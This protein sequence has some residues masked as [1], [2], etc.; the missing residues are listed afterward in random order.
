MKT[1]ITIQVSGGVVTAVHSSSQDTEI[2][3]IDYDN[4]AADTLE[5]EATARIE[6]VTPFEVA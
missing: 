2:E 4:D 3:I 1:H 5:K 6:V